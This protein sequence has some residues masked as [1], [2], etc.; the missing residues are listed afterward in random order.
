MKITYLHASKFGNGAQVA[1]EFK[2]HLAAR[3]VAVEVHHIREI[4]A[5]HLPAAD[6]YLFSSPGRMGRPIGSMRRFLKKADLPSGT[7]YA[8]LTTEGAPRPDKKTGRMPTA[9]EIAKYE[10]VR[11]TMN[12]I[13]RGK[14]L[15]EVAEDAVYV[16]GM[17]GPLED[18][19]R[20]KVD[21]FAD[22][23]P[24]AS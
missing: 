5:R 19:W 1:E 11:P 13:L 8:L 15:V 23:L 16:T 22:H 24:I 9:E 18:G 10:K 14:G 7:K 6:L 12:D 2:E 20:D 4:D 17:R 3:G 21:D